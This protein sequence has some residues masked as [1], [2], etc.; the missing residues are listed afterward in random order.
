M[1]SAAVICGVVL[2]S[3]MLGPA[4]LTA[5]QYPGR[6]ARDLRDRNSRLAV[7]YRQ[8]LLADVSRVMVTWRDAW[9]ADDA[10][11]LARLYSDK[12]VIIRPIHGAAYR[13]HGEIEGF[14]TEVLP[15]VRAISTDVLDLDVADRMAYLVTK[16]TSSPSQGIGAGGTM[17]GTLV[18]VFQL[19]GRNWRIRSQTFLDES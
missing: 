17:H 10:S 16:Y 14:F 19:E 2:S 4:A 8:G 1:R 3:I 12:G 9:E 18:S 15:T 13:G 11:S 5:Q 6:S 7:E